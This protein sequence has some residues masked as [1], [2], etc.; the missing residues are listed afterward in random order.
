MH[1]FGL[2]LEGTDNRS[3][4]TPLHVNEHQCEGLRSIPFDVYPAGG[5]QPVAS[6]VTLANA[7]FAASV[8]ADTYEVECS[9]PGGHL[10]VTQV[11][12][13]NP[14]N[15]RSRETVQRETREMNRP[16]KRFL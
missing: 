11:A 5:T 13:A 10:M 14:T 3:D 12:V 4:W 8:G 2:F 15:H 16:H 1:I 7:S 9:L 6:S